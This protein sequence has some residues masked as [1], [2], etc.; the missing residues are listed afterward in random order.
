MLVGT[1][2]IAAIVRQ[3]LWRPDV[4]RA[5]AYISDKLVAKATRR[6][7]SDKRDRLVEMVLTV[8]KPNYAER[9][10]IKK[11]KAAGE[12]LPLKRP[13]LKFKDYGKT[14]KAA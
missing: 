6:H 11:C 12:P 8:G 3:I 1:A 4:Y 5:T 7:K 14:K 10:F 9:Q 2:D 13:Q